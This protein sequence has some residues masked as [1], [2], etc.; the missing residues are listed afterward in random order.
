M[1]SELR[2]RAMRGFTLIELLV[3][4][5]I[6]ALLIG[7]LLPALSKARSSALKAGCLSSL[8]QISI[9]NQ[10]YQDDNNDLMPIDFGNRGIS[11]Y[12]YG[13][14]WPTEDSEVPKM[15]LLKPH[16][17]PL[18]PYAHPNLPLGDE[19]TSPKDLEDPDQYDFPVFRCPADQDYHYQ[20]TNGQITFST[21]CYYA[22]GTS[23]MFNLDWYDDAPAPKTESGVK[24][25]QRARSKYPSRFISFWDD[26]MDY[27][28]WR[29][30][31]A[32]DVVSHH[33]TPG[34]HSMVFLDGHAELQA[35]DYKERITSQYMTT[36]PEW[37]DN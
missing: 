36:F 20:T 21:N 25:F 34:V 11:N 4:I 18:N 16:R 1:H 15:F 35:V 27:T 10:M 37:I 2:C 23:Y 29:Q 30:K 8:H 13:G 12:N 7:L 3:V 24:M 5:S 9:A 32:K 31:E 28:F 6:I 22:I 17:R 26:P 33:G 14:R 19:K